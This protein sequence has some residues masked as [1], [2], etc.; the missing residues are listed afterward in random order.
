M[1]GLKES[2]RLMYSNTHLKSH[3]TLPLT[4]YEWRQRKENECS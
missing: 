2:F 4:M 1:I 3:E